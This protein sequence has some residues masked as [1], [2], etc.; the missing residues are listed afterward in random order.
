MPRTPLLLAL[1]LSAASLLGAC[2]GRLEDPDAIAD[3]VAA[4]AA[5]N[6]AGVRDFTLHGDDLVIYFR[7]AGADSLATFE[8]RAFTDDSLRE[9]V[10]LPYHLPNAMELARGLRGN[11]RLAGT[12]DL[13]GERVYVLDAIDPAA[14]TGAETA[15]DSLR[16]LVDARTFQIREIRVAEPPPTDSAAT[17]DP[18]APPLVTRQRYGDFRTAD[19]LTLPFYTN[20]LITG[21][22]VPDE[23]RLVQGGMLEIQRRQAQALPPAERARALRR[24]E[25]Q[26]R[27]IRQGEFEQA[28]S[29]D[30]VRVN[31]GV[32]EDAFVPP[33]TMPWT[34]SG[35]AAG[36][37]AP[38]PPAPA[39]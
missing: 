8:G 10:A 28:F 12:A 13:D 36:A 17:P 2:Q 9:A 22:P 18:D 29:V 21:I 15:I 14:V 3:R 16:V 11:A 33:P 24:I 6:Y 1:L 31:A 34:G 30:A 27:I 26:I 20:T 23:V 35:D 37:A 39:P 38:P 19:G 4:R 5:E 25:T 7:R 32:P